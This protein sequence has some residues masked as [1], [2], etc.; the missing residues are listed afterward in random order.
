[1]PLIRDAFR[2]SRN[3][4]LAV[5]SELV[6]PAVRGVTMLVA[7]RPAPPSSW[8]KGLIISHT[9]IG[10]LLYRTGSL[11]H[12]ASGLPHCKWYYLCSKESASVLEGR[13]DLA[14][15]LPYVVGED[16][17][18]LAPGARE[19]LRA[20]RFDVA[21]CTNT[22]RHYPDLL[23]SVSLGIPTRVGYDHKGFSGL[24]TTP[25][26]VDYPSPFPAYFR[27]MTR[28]IADVQDDWPLKPSVALEPTD[29]QLAN[30]FYRSLN[31]GDAPL[32]A[33]C[34]TTRQPVGGW[35]ANDLLLAAEQ[36]ATATG[37]HVV[38]CGGPVP[39]LDVLRRWR[40]V[41]AN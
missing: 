39:S 15:V 18:T 28:Q 26:H 17:W 14:G 22:L 1:M 33:C 8:S 30:D 2:Y 36:V 11:P 12:L 5:L 31:V 6:S 16:S 20:H 37:A 23:L 34:P 10:D 3:Y 4:Y 24:I 29:I 25:V 41:R 32:L 9:H 27:T 19:T 21:L 7:R 40:P 13:S 35:P 38:L